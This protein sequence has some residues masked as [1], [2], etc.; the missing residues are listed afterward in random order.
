M[1]KKTKHDGVLI[2]YAIH[3]KGYR[4]LTDIHKGSIVETM[5]V[6]FAERL[7]DNP[8]TLLSMPDS[9]PDDYFA[10]YPYQDE[11]LTMLP[12]TPKLKTLFI[13]QRY[14]QSTST[15]KITYSKIPLIHT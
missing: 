6:T 3:T 15:Y 11:S 2:G 8:D 14:Q 13:R 12:T 4:I 10:G 5:H 7:Q 1:A 9:N